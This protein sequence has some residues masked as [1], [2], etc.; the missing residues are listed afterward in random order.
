MSPLLVQ[1]PLL[2]SSR[3]IQAARLLAGLDKRLLGNMH[4]VS[5]GEVQYL[6]RSGL[7]GILVANPETQNIFTAEQ[8]Q[9][10][11]IE[12]QRIAT[13]NLSGWQAFLPVTDQLQNSGTR[14]LLLKGGA[15]AQQIYSLLTIR[16]MTDFDLLIQPADADRVHQ[17]MVSAGCTAERALV[18]DDFYPRYFYEK[19]Y[20]LPGSIRFR[21][22]MHVRPFR[23]L[24]YCRM[25]PP[26]AFWDQPATLKIESREL[27]GLSPEN[28]LIHLMTHS[29]IHG[30][31]RALWLYD[32][33]QVIQ[34]MGS[35]VDWPAFFQKVA[36]WRLGAA[37]KTTFR[38]LAETFHESRYA[39]WALQVRGRC[40]WA[41]RLVLWQAPRDEHHPVRH[42]LVNLL[43]TPGW[44]FR[45]GYLQAVL[46]PGATH[47]AEVYPYR[48]PGWLTV[49]HLWRWVRPMI[50]VVQRVQ[51]RSGIRLQPKAAQFSKTD[52]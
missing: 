9:R 38:I 16:P 17:L 51:G 25:L 1:P 10:L 22:D 49:A 20:R 35:V 12:A 23:P 26:D 13:T 24:R 36:D 11:L 8:Y 3:R 37:V 47:M 32:I 34:Q 31:Q 29:A 40:S 41:D 7:A 4:R 30:H 52:S 28:L 39:E 50:R 18:R 43:T 44:R 14:F 46:F 42:L 33:Y 6:I 2:P 45:L 48:H 27:W 21:V 5:D 19:E 15:L